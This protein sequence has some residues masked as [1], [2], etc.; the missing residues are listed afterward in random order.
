MAAI[1]PGDDANLAANL[2]EL[3]LNNWSVKLAVTLKTIT[4]AQVFR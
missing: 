4:F 2:S 1:N 3:P